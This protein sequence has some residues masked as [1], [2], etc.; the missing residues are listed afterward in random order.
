[1]NKTLGFHSILSNNFLEGI[2]IASLLHVS[3]SAELK[4]IPNCFFK[5]LS[6]SP[7]A[8]RREFPLIPIRRSFGVN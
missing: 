2:Y 7:S 6:P 3:K 1:M 5:L 8:L 4:N